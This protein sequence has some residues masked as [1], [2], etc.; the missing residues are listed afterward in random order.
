MDNTHQIRVPIRDLGCGA[1]EPIRLERA[2]RSIEG[3]LTAYVN[4]ATDI[5]YVVGDPAVVDA[6]TGGRVLARADFSPRGAVE[7]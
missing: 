1:A 5:A 7:S 6:P 4:P 3:V 2:L